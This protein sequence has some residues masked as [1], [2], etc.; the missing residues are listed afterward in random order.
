[1]MKPRQ[2]ALCITDLD[3]GGAERALVELAIR[4]DRRRF[5]P[6]V[7][8]L[9]GRPRA[10]AQSLLPRLQS[11]GVTTYCLG[12]RSNWHFPA[13][14]RRLVG[15]LKQ[16]APEL[17]Q[18]F[19]FHANLLGR[20]AARLAG[21]QRVVCSIRVAERWHRWHLWLDRATDRLVDRHVCVS[22]AVA[23]FSAK[24]ARLPPHKLV[25][26]PNGVDCARLAA[27][28]P[29][30]LK[31]FGIPPGCRA[32]VSIGRLDRQKGFQWLLTHARRWLGAIDDYHLLIVGDGPLR[33]ALERLVDRLGEL[34]RRV[35]LAGWR[36]DVPE[37]LAASSLFVLGSRWEGMP[38][39]VL[40][41]MGAGLPVV[42]TDVEGVRELLGPA[43]DRQ[44]APPDDPQQ[45]AR[46]ILAILSQPAL[47]EELAAANRRRAEAEF[48]I[49]RMVDGY[50]QLWEQLLLGG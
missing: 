40:V 31:A 6:V 46:K 25:V 13:V 23:D 34:A 9:A 24:T 33:L 7:Y 36:A 30:D 3:C 10:P 12:G 49:E 22:Q 50:Q 21:V 1:M 44:I 38:N 27:A 42:A 16:Q 4:M 19:L 2:I 32:V 43:A 5:A 11:A 48:G 14:L 29:A 28:R 45:F 41:G 37:I 17:L 20:I 26:I 8:C 18:C 15:R 47:A 35:H 39:V